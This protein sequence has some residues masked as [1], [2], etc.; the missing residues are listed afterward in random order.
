MKFN[1]GM[2]LLVIGLAGCIDLDEERAR[3]ERNGGVVIETASTSNRRTITCLP[4]NYNGPVPLP[5]LEEG[6]RR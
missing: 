4:A 3:C 6:R 2:V 1:T 5:V